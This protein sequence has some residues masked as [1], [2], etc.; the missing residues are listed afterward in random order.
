V[1]NFLSA[2]YTKGKKFICQPLY[3]DS[4]SELLAWSGIQ[5]RDTSAPVQNFVRLELLP[6]DKSE[7]WLDV[8][9]WREKV[10][11]HEVPEWF[12]EAARFDAF[13]QMREVI[14]D[15]ITDEGGRLTFG[16]LM[17]VSTG[18]HKVRGCKVFSLGNSTVKALD[19]S[20]VKALDNSTVKALGNSTVKACGNSTVEAWDNST[21][22]AC[23]N[24]TVEA[25]DNSTVKALDNSTVKALG[26]STVKALGNS[27]V[28]AL[29]FHR[30]SII[31]TREKQEVLTK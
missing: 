15:A 4:H 14:A 20:T 8:A 5:E 6:P 13:E 1:C 21:V 17:I 2:L 28:K 29:R 12:D 26:N 9:N 24:S 11:E 31:D 27:T 18:R 10:D 7:D 16:K 23:G 19:N 3:T 22:K 25:W 30:G